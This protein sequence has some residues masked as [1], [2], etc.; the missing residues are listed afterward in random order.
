[1]YINFWYPM[2]RSE[3]LGPDRPERATCLGVDFVV[4]RDEDGSARVLSDTCVHR[5]GSL[6]GPWELRGRPRIIDG[7]VV[8]PYHGW[9]FGGDG[10]CRNIPSIGYGTRPPARA[11]V[12][13]YPTLEKY[14]IVFAFLGD[15]P[16]QERPPL[17]DVKEW[18]DPR[19]RANPVVVLDV[20]YYYERSIENGLD[21]A[22]NEFVHPTHGHMAINR[23]TYRVNDYEV[24]D[25]SQGWGLWFQHRFASPGLK[26]PT[27]KGTD[28]PPGDVYAGSGT[29][30]P[31]AM[32]TEINLGPNLCFR[33]YF[34][35]QPVSEN[36]TRIFF[37]NLRNFMLEAEHDGPIHARN[38]AVARQDIEILTDLYPLRTPVSNTKEVLTPS[39]KAVVAYRDWLARFDDRGWR[40]D[41][42]EFRARNGTGEIAFAIPSPGRRSSGNWV[43]ETVPLLGNRQARSRAGGT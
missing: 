43:L 7:C 31:N 36:R 18:D 9:E 13:S 12:D 15:L 23:A 22:H 30:G 32:F 26:H 3:D 16:E 4:F 19:W 20:P 34:I 42:N 21:P 35:E 2:I 33:G 29:H 39:D 14:G 25:F 17:I 27:W 6:S 40:I 37:L 41:W 28:A 5:G 1:M 24:A 38:K 11:K 8:C 10:E